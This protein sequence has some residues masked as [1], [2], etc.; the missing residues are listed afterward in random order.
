MV[1]E[2]TST[3][4]LRDLEISLRTNNIEW[5]KEFLSDEY[6]GLDV[7]IDYLSFRLSMMRHEQ[8]IEEAKT[9]SMERMNGSTQVLPI[10]NTTTTMERTVNGSTYMRPPLG[11]LLDSPN[12]KR[13]SKHV[14]KLNMGATTD[15]IHVCI[16]CLRAI[17]NNKYGFNMMIQHREAINSI[18][19]SLIHK[20]LRTKALV[21]ELLAAICLVKGGHEIILSAFDNFKRVC[22]ELRRFQ[23]LMDYFMNFADFHIDFLIAC[24]QFV[25]IVVHSVEDMNYRVHLQYEFTTLGLDDYLVKL[26]HSESEELQVQI[27]AYLDNMFDVATLMEDSETKNAALERVNELEE[28]LSRTIDRLNSVEQEML[29][30]VGDRDAE[31]ARLRLERDELLGKLQIYEEEVS[32]LKAFVRKLEQDTKNRESM[33]IEMENLQK[34]LPKGTSLAE[35]SKMLAEGKLASMGNGGIPNGIGTKETVGNTPAPAPPPPPPALPVVAPPPPVNLQIL[36]NLFK[37]LIQFSFS[38]LS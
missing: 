4:V 12:S 23:T 29:F 14:A 38:H 8:R 35:I 37:N 32:N 13:R 30:K 11:Q 36:T 28:D 10:T 6:Q 24:M 3:Q 21:L 18:A 22:D 16:M 2:S 19:L 34:T 9:E 27:S 33:I 31:I 25:N 20:S 15:D 5:V 17:M 26:R 1:G 7:L